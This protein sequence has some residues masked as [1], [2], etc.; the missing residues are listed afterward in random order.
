MGRHAAWALGESGAKAFSVFY[1]FGTRVFALRDKN[2]KMPLG[3]TAI[4]AL[5]S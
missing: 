3:V 2:S 1:Y 5:L 4:A